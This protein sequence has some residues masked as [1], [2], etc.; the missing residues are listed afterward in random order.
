[1]IG[2]LGDNGAIMPCNRA[3]DAKGQVVGFGTGAYEHA[4]A[5]ITG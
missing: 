1:M 3:G 4:H 2:V 5:E